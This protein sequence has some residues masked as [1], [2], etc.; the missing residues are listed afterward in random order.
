MKFIRGLA[1]VGLALFVVLVGFW[2]ANA[3]A[4]DDAVDSWQVSYVVDDAGVLHVQETLVYRFGSNSGRH[5]IDRTLI[6]REPW[7]STDQD[8]V[9]KISHIKVTSPDASATFSTSTIGVGRD[10]QIDIRVGSAD[11]VVSAPTA[12]YTLTYD[13]EGAMRTSDDASN[14]YDELYWD[15]IGD[16]TPQV[17]NIVITVQVPGGVK[18]VAC[19]NGPATTNNPCTS[20]TVGTDGVATYVVALKNANDIVT[21]GA[22]ITPGLVSN[23]QPNLQQRADVASQSAV[24]TG[25][26]T[27][28]GVAVVTAVGVGVMAHRKRRDERFLGVAPG[29]ID[30][31]GNGVGVDNHPVI[32]VSF[33]PPSIPVAAAGLIDDG[34]VDVRD[35]T[36]ALLSLA[37][38]GAIQLRQDQTRPKLWVFQG[39]A[40][41][42]IYARVVNPNV[43]MAPHEAKL[44]GDIFAGLPNG[45]EKAL[46]GQGTLV[47]AHA[48]MQRNVRAE[49][50]KAG[51]Y[52]RMPAEGLTAAVAGPGAAAANVVKKLFM[53]VWAIVFCG[54]AVMSGFTLG[55]V[56]PYLSW[57]TWGGP[58]IVLLVGFVVYKGLTN[59]GQRSA[60]GRAYADQ[61]AGFRE[62]LAT[63]EAD[64]IKFEEG[65]DIFSQY[66]PWAVIYGLT[67]RWAKICADLVAAGRLDNMQPSWYYGNPGSF[68]V[69]VFTG[70]LQ[71]VNAAAMPVASSSGSG[72]GG[73]SA[74]GG[75][76]FSGGGG[77]GGGVGSW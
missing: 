63:A 65:E 23:N 16:N 74:F 38:R 8:A 36:G 58:I 46:S 34:A 4:V 73:G 2:P 52:A 19:F 24:R 25:L 62:Y 26:G 48:D 40:E 14:P 28:G 42:T 33:A 7:G 20:A 15:A 71:S 70:G 18:D 35:T 59:R 75:G 45:T 44:I 67:D 13:V 66:L 60:L 54:I 27:T 41:K 11:Q 6:T 39:T 57:L 68:N 51:W 76:G 47:K 30:P 1:G 49:A 3:W 72:F 22:K 43:A 29:S 69:F 53:A 56:A 77:G 9:Y 21:I 10:Q 32:P 31:S 12:T 61:V 5:G 64:Q 37:V 17:G 50:E 55:A